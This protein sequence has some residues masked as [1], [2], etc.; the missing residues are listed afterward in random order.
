MNLRDRN[1]PCMRMVILDLPFGGGFVGVAEYHTG[2]PQFC[3]FC[4]IRS[5]YDET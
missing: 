2:Q 4:R 5:P 3:A 1:H